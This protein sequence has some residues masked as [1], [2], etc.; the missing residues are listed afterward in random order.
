MSHADLYRYYIFT[1]MPRLVREDS[2]SKYADQSH[3]RELALKFPPLMGAMIA[4][5][6]MHLSRSDALYTQV[7]VESYLYSIHGLQESIA[8][9]ECA[10]NEDGLLATAISL[11]IFEV[12]SY[13]QVVGYIINQVL[14]NSRSDAP[15]NINPHVTAAGTLLALRHPNR[16]TR[17]SAAA[18]FERICV[19]SFVYHSALM[20]LFHPSL[21]PLASPKIRIDLERY[22]TDPVHLDDTGS[23]TSVSTQ[24]ILD[25]SYTFFLLIADITRLARTSRSLSAMECIQWHGLRGEL[26]QW[27]TIINRSE[28]DHCRNHSGVLC[29]VAARILL[30]K[31]DPE[32]ST[33][34]AVSEMQKHLGVGLSLLASLDTDRVFTNYYLWPLTILGSISV[35]PS[36]QQVIRE[37]MTRLGVSRPVGQANWVLTRL[38]RVWKCTLNSSEPW[39]AHHTPQGL[40]LLLNG[41]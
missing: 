21:D 17:S 16:Q 32:V 23:G 29:A 35:R 39:K 5:A 26:A 6:A 22:F 3:M 7:A 40:Q 15:P 38:E 2:L 34:E 14:Q 37:N 11:C 18:A 41:A 20:M 24:P 4:I 30:Q 9:N 25:R 27:E 1:V 12:R 8:H 28:Q 36:D 19:E 33:D 13:H 31:T 10:G